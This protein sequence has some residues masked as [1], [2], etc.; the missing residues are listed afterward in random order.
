M[1]NR[2]G[3]LVVSLDFEMLWGLAEFDVAGAAVLSEKVNEIVPELLNLFQQYGIHATWATV[4]AIMESHE[5]VF[6]NRVRSGASPQVRAKIEKF[7]LESEK[8]EHKYRKCLFAPHLIKAIQETPDQEIGTHTYSHYYCDLP[9]STVEAF[10]EEL[11]FSTEAAKQHGIEMHSVVFPKNQVIKE[12]LSAVQTMGLNAYRG[13]E[14]GVLYRKRAKNPGK[15]MKI[16]YLDNYIPLQKTCSYGVGEVMQ[17]GM[18]NVRSSRFFK[19]YRK[20][21]WYAEGMK[22]RRYQKEMRDA[23]RR[24]EIYHI[25][26]H[27]HNMA[28][29]CEESFQQIEAFLKYFLKMKERYGMRSM[30]MGEVAAHCSLEAHKN[31]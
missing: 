21:Y 10:K 12:Y 11:I 15:W 1:V 18:Y 7:D 31:G 19:P 5:A 9:D 23:A 25:Y 20:K 24:G 16:L 8:G 14:T 29:D 2:E 30:S 17:G 28:K 4:G 3:I 27:P 13:K 26:W 22:L 6:C